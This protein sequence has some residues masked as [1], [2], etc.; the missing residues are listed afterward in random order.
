MTSIVNIPEIIATLKAEVTVLNA[1]PWW[2]FWGPPM[3][4]PTGIYLTID[5]VSQTYTNFYRTARLQFNFLAHSE[6]VSKKS[7]VDAFE[8]LNGYITNK[9]RWKLQYWAFKCVLTRETNE[10][11]I[12]TSEVWWKK[13]NVLIKD[14]FITFGK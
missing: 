14:Y 8:I 9:C 6:N 10:T 4:E 1:F 13:R 2:I 12:F 7:L 5:L 3:S 11:R